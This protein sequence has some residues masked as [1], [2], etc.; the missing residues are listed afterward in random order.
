MYTRYDNVTL[1]SLVLQL[2]AKADWGLRYH[3]YMCWGKVFQ[4]L[5][6]DWYKKVSYFCKMKF[7][8]VHFAADWMN[9]FP[10]RGIYQI[11]NIISWQNSLWHLCSQWIHSWCNLLFSP[12]MYFYRANQYTFPTRFH[13]IHKY[14]LNIRK[15]VFIGYTNVFGPIIVLVT[16]CFRLE[17]K[18]YLPLKLQ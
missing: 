3:I 17:Q 9:K 4:W 15:E 16:N 7:V 6:K 2:G 11:A 5:P 10:N 12:N 1:I 13:V 8:Y 14:S 18:S